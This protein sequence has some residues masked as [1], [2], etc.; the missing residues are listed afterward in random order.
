VDSGFIINRSQHL[1]TGQELQ[2]G[3]T[4]AGLIDLQEVVLA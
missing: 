4:D 1:R 2:L 3:A